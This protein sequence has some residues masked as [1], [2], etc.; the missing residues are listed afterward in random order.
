MH[1]TKIKK[2]ISFHSIFIHL[3]L[4]EFTLVAVPFKNNNVKLTFFFFFYLG[5]TPARVEAHNSEVV[6]LWVLPGQLQTEDPSSC[7]FP[8]VSAGNCLLCKGW[9]RDHVL[10]NDLIYQKV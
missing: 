2:N 9:R 7:S 4:F 10:K 3:K 1:L 5:T 6:T 8:V